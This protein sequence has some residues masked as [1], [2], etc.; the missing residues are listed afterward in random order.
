MNAA[1]LAAHGHDDPARSFHTRA[2]NDLF[3]RLRG[4]APR[5]IAL[6]RQ[7]AASDRTLI[8]TRFPRAP[9]ESLDLAQLDEPASSDEPFDLIHS[10]GDLEWRPSLRRRLPRL[11]QRLRPGGWLAAVLPNDLYEPYRALARMVAAEGP[12][13]AT[14]L[15]VAKT[16]PFNPTL[17]GLYATLR[18]LCITVEIW[19]TTYLCALPNIEA[20]VDFAREGA[21]APFLARLDA[22][23]RRPYL[24]RYRD[25]LDGAYPP[26]ADGAILV[27]LPR[28]FV[29]AER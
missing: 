22:D 23:Q 2:A 26:Q 18:P 21:L 7:D 3:N 20:I 1:P 28:I 6:L 14:L 29:L 16:R 13:A 25:E 24:E 11:T 5:R 4:A 9:V 12:W 17:E 8:E 10:L 19:E 15:P 27:R